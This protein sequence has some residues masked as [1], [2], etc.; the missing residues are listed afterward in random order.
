MDIPTFDW[1]MLLI[2]SNNGHLR[3][4]LYLWGPCDAL[5]T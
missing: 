4:I 1:E 3:Q 5:G 2:V